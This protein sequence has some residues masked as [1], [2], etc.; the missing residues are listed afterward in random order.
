MQVLSP[1]LLGAVAQ[2]V[3]QVFRPLR[4]REKSFDE[5]AEI[6]SSSSADDGQVSSPLNFA[7][8]DLAQNLPRLASIFSSTDA[9]E[10]IHTIQQVMRNFGTLRR[11]GLGRADFKF[12]V[13]RNRV[14]VDDLAAKAP[15]DSER[16]SGL[17]A[18]RGTQHDDD[19][20]FAVCHFPNLGNF[21]TFS[22]RSKG[23]TASS[24]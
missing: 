15:R 7:Q 5:S 14:A 18:R 21:A 17:A 23:C 12:A 3:A 22:A 16:Q 1:V 8:N 20:R 10:R 19:Q 9:G 13:H 2:A 4:T 11:T 24:G 6:E